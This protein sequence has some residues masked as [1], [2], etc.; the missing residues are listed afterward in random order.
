[1][2]G[3]TAEVSRSIKPLYEENC[4]GV[5][6][7]ASRWTR[8]DGLATPTG[9]VRGLG[10]KATSFLRQILRLYAASYGV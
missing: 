5:K 2:D 1:M 10:V 3:F 8:R 9:R 7:L 4:Y 6:L